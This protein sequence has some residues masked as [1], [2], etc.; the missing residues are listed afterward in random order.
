MTKAAGSRGPGGLGA[1][2]S[3]EKNDARLRSRLR[4]RIAT[5]TRKTHDGLRGSGA[6]GWPEGVVREHRG[7]LSNSFRLHL[8]VGEQRHTCRARV[9]EAR[10]RCARATDR[11][12]PAPPNRSRRASRSMASSCASSRARRARSRAGAGVL[13]AERGRGT[14]GVRW[15]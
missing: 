9:P 2:L 8:Q 3:G 15:E 1:H 5:T 11:P 13:G 12:S 10:A 6:L 4:A 7:D 14:R